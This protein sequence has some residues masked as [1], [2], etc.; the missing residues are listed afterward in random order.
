MTLRTRGKEPFTRAAILVLALGTLLAA[1][2]GCG[3]PTGKGMP[4]Q[5][6]PSAIGRAEPD[7]LPS[8]TMEEIVAAWPYFPHA[9]YAQAGFNHLTLPFRTDTNAP[10]A[11]EEARAFA[12][13]LSNA[14][15]W[16]PGNYC[17]RH[18]YF[19]F[20]RARPEMLA[21]E[22]AYD[23]QML[24]RQVQ[25]WRATHAI[26]GEIRK[27]PGGYVGQLQIFDKAGQLSLTQAY[28]EPRS[29]FDLLG[30]MCDACSR[31]VGHE[32]TPALSAHFR[33]PRCTKAESLW[34]LGAAAFQ[35]ERT[36]EEFQCYRPI[37]ERDPQFAEVR[38]W[39]A[40]QSY[41]Q[42]NDWARYQQE[43]EKCLG[44]YLT[45]AVLSDYEVT[46]A[47][48]ATYARFVDA[49]QAL[50]GSNAPGVV[51]WR[52]RAASDRGDIPPEL[53]VRGLAT[54][55]RYPNAN[56]L[57]GLLGNLMYGPPHGGADAD[58]AVALALTQLGSPYLRGSS[59]QDRRIVGKLSQALTALGREDIA[60]AFAHANA[61]AYLEDGDVEHGR[62]SL[63]QLAAACR[64]MRQFETAIRVCLTAVST[65]KGSGQDIQDALLQAAVCAAF[66]GDT[67]TFDT[68]DGRIRT[69]TNDS[70]KRYLLD[71]YRQLLAGKPVDFGQLRCCL[72]ADPLC[73]REAAILLAEADLARGT[74]NE[75]G[76]VVA[77]L[78][79]CPN[80]REL[81][82]LFDAYDRKHP[83]RE[84]GL[85]YESLAWL[86][87]ESAWV[88]QA[89]KDYRARAKVAAAP[90]P[91]D[92]EDLLKTL[93]PAAHIVFRA[94]PAGEA[95]TRPIPPGG[96][97]LVA[98]QLVAGGEKQRARDLVNRYHS[99]A[100]HSDENGGHPLRV[101]CSHLLHVLNLTERAGAAAP[102]LS[103]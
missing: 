68:L 88:A 84:A 89:V 5:Q 91:A 96:I 102:R 23:G 62:T 75:C 11:R 25:R 27:A 16:V 57:L 79:R 95:L 81:W 54:A 92:Y 38:Y 82:V 37:L 60:T 93:A 26:G 41:W 58:L 77:L 2:G 63:T 17:A 53:L 52:I 42:N 9:P 67:G 19:V 4:R 24:A 18:A 74:T 85:F 28:T 32:P 43:K 65:M 12:F 13:L 49:A 98:R 59:D 55:A 71:G 40:N 6:R 97:A 48:V 83:R 47:N 10:H 7:T 87:P 36:A 31:H 103:P 61:K 3:R 100:Y 56:G 21:L 76:H 64:S 20:K 69:L 101:Y 73:R 39:I 50:V 29:Y 51:E 45:E 72:T 46:R 80:D 44:A 86:H 70:F 8:P 90:D 34:D 33:L 30:D 99:Y 66:V 78:A 1:A 22:Q 15:D 14:L 94:L 35:E